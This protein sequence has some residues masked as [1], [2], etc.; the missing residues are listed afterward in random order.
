MK[1]IY[2]VEDI[3]AGIYHNPLIMISDGEA[4]RSFT[5]AAN[6]K[7][8]SIGLN[9]ED[10]RMWSVGEYNETTGEI[11]LFANKVLLANAQNL[12]R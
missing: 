10:Y 2:M 5:H 1:R 7:E 8:T 4:H 11:L 12:V 3:K 6:N 9:P